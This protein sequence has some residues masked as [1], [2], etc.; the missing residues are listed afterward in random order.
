MRILAVLA[1][2]MA[3]RR[4]DSRQLGA[5]YEPDTPN[6]RSYVRSRRKK[7]HRACHTTHLARFTPLFCSYE[8]LAFLVGLAPAFMY[9]RDVVMTMMGW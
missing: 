5:I 4:G 3:E 8:A 9:K 7:M 2:V 6:S 1:L